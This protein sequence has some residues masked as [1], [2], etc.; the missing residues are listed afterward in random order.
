MKTRNVTVKLP[1][2]LLRQAKMY[3]AEHDTTV[4]AVNRQLLEER[5]AGNTCVKVATQRFLEL[6]ELGPYSPIDP[7]SSRREELYERW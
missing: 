7:A 2:D 1:A 3:A 4:N 6:A 5:L